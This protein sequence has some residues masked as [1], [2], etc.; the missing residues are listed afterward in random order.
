M[1]NTIIC[2]LIGFVCFVAQAQLKPQNGVQQSLPQCVAFTNAKIYVSPQQIIEEG[3][4]V[5]KMTK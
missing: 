5:I 4:L 2:F 1:K 3:T